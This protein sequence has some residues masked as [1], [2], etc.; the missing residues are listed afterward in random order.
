MPILLMMMHK[1]LSISNYCYVYSYMLQ[2]GLVTLFGKKYAQKM[3]PY[4]IGSEYST[5]AR[6][7]R[8]DARRLVKIL[9]KIIPLQ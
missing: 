6:V 8:N 4:L 5:R 3:R 7:L 1:I 9:I 2:N